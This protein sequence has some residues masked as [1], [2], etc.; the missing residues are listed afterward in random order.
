MTTFICIFLLIFRQQN[1]HKSK[2]RKHQDQTLQVFWDASVG[3]LHSLHPKRLVVFD[4]D[5][6][7]V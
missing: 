1:N 6:F 2:Q 7:F 4:L 3:N 5:V